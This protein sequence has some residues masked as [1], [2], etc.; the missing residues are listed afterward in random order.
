MSLDACCP[1]LGEPKTKSPKLY[2]ASALQ[3]ARKKRVYINSTFKQYKD[4]SPSIFK[5]PCEETSYETPYS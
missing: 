3:M 5:E 2:Y 1:S 4:L